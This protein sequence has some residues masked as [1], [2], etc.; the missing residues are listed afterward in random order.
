MA[1]R[2]PSIG[3]MFGFIWRWELAVW[4]YHQI[5]GFAYMIIMI[6]LALTVLYMAENPD[7]N[8]TQTTLSVVKSVGLWSAREIQTHSEKLAYTYGTDNCSNYRK[9][10]W[11]LT[12][13]PDRTEHSQAIALECETGGEGV[14]IPQNNDAAAAVWA[15]EN[16][17]F[18]YFTD[19][20]KDK[21]RRLVFEAARRLGLP[22]T[23]IPGQ[24]ATRGNYS[25]AYDY[26]QRS[27]DFAKQRRHAEL[28]ARW[29][30]PEKQRPGIGPK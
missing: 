24:P 28:V 30:P 23:D 13:G 29:N 22:T 16:S 18:P 21:Q 4:L 26:A 12:Y 6:I 25:K 7:S 27:W 19:L 15:R 11:N 9:N 3:N 8:L 10:A 14:G 1:Y 17:E 5:F 20:P 2:G